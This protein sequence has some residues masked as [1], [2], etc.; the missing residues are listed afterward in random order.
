VPG[1]E[2]F[3]SKEKYRRY[4]AYKHMHGIPSHAK[5]V[6]VAG[7]KHKVKHSGKKMKK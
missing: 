2:H 4:N 3:Q 1:T 5:D 7:K 6:V